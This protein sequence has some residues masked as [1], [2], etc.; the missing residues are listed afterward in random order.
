MALVSLLHCS[1]HYVVIVV[2]LLLKHVSVFDGLNVYKTSH[3]TISWGP[4]AI[5]LLKRANLIPFEKPFKFRA[6][7]NKDKP[8]SRYHCVTSMGT[9]T[10]AMDYFV[11]QE[12][13]HNCGP[14]AGCKMMDLFRVPG[15]SI[16]AKRLEQKENRKIV[17]ECYCKLADVCEPDLGVA[18]REKDK[19]NH[20]KEDKDK[21]KK[22]ADYQREDEDNEDNKDK[23][24]EVG[25]DDVNKEHKDKNNQD[26]ENKDEDKREVKS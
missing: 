13:G 3:S 16:P 24:D 6:V 12:D 25:N 14:I 15:L 19:S 5:F 26:K 2:D 4:Y 11:K 18:D 7:K 21:D 20:D 8:V 9:H 10:L 17:C 23:K 1:S 22:E